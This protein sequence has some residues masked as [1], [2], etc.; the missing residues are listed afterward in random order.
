MQQ[1]RPLCAEQ[2]NLRPGQ[3]ERPFAPVGV[4]HLHGCCLAPTNRQGRGQGPGGEHKSRPLEAKP[5]NTQI[6]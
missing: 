3:R 5:N 4:R 6:Y 1:R 2:G